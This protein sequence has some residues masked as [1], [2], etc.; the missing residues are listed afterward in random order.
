VLERC[1]LF[2]GADPL[3]LGALIM[4]LKPRSLRKA[5]QIIRKASR[6]RDV[7]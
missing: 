1:D 7:T 2:K 6:S 4:V 5:R 3:F